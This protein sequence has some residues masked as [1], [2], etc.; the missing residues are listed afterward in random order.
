[1]LIL[2][3]WSRSLPFQR[4][5]LPFGLW[6]IAPAIGAFTAEKFIEHGFR[7][8]VFREVTR[9]FEEARR[10]LLQTN[11]GELD[12]EP[13]SGRVGTNARREAVQISRS[14]DGELHLSAIR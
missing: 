2:P 10:G 12:Q 4:L 11:I 1:M 5:F 7:T 3:E 9:D 13:G 14:P 8:F 6:P